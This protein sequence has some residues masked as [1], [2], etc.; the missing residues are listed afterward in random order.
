MSVTFQPVAYPIFGGTDTKVSSFV[1]PAPKL[2][3]VQNAYSSLTGS[4]QRR[5]GRTAI[6][7]TDTNAVAITSFKALATYKGGLLGFA[8][9]TASQ[10]EKV[11][12]KSSLGWV[13]RGQQ[14]SAKVTSQV[15]LSSA[16]DIWFMDHATTA[17]GITVYAANTTVSAASVIAV[18]IQDSNGVTLVNNYQIC[19]SGW[20]PRVV[21]HG[22]M[23][24]IVYYDITNTRISC[25]IVDTSTAALMNSTLAAASTSVATDMAVLLT[26]A[27]FDIVDNAT[28]GVF[29]AY[30]SNVANTLKWGFINSS[31]ALVSTSTYLAG[32]AA[33]AI[34]VAVATGDAMHGISYLTTLGANNVFTL[35]RSWNGAAWTATASSATLGGGTIGASV[36]ASRFDSATQLRVFWSGDEVVTTSTGFNGKMTQVTY[37]T[38]G[39]ITAGSTLRHTSIAS[40]PFAGPTGEHYII[41]TTSLGAVTDLQR[42]L[43]VYR[44]ADGVAARLVGQL[45]QNF[46]SNVP[47][48][49]HLAQVVAVSATKWS[50][51]GGYNIDATNGAGLGFK[52]Y[53]VEWA[54]GASHK[55]IEV[56]ESL[57]VAGSIPMQ[58]DGVSFTESGFLRYVDTSDVVATPS[59]GAGSM[60]PNL[61]YSYRVIPMWTNARGERDLGTDSGAITV[62]LGAA[63]DTVTLSIP[64]IAHTFKQGTTTSVSRANLEFAIYRTEDTPTSDS[65]FYLVGTVANNPAADEVTYVDGATDASILDEVTLDEESLENI[66]PP[67]GYILAQAGGRQWIAGVPGKP[68]TIV[69][70]KTRLP[71]E[72]ILWT[73]ALTID[74]P[75]AGGAIVAMEALGETLVIFKESRIYRMRADVGPNNTGTLGSFLTPELVS[76]DTGCEGQR[77]VAVCP[78]GLMFDGVKGIMLLDQSFGVK[79]IGAPVENDTSIGTV[80][81]AVCL[82]SQQQV[83]FSGSSRTHVYDY[84]HSQWY[85]FTHGSQGPTVEWNDVHTAIHSANVVAYDD[86]ATFYDTGTTVYAM[87]ITLGW[88]KLPQTLQGDMRIQRIGL[89]GIQLGA[90]LSLTV[91][92]YKNF[93][94]TSA[95]QTV[96]VTSASTGVFIRQPRLSQQVVSALRVSITDAV[97]LTATSTA[98]L[99]LNEVVFHVG[100]RGTGLAR[101]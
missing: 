45:E 81:G 32:G 51:P 13:D 77:S 33:V 18:T 75:E 64:T 2:S 20:A 59:N 31:G 98:G 38:G 47:L 23:V 89:T 25:N 9:P 96:E 69:A 66:A 40:K 37:T 29:I 3:L 15:I 54:H 49:G 4:L 90:N 19:A 92:L 42:A 43:Y 57:Y 86:P 1:L 97:G 22:T 80:N 16:D 83:R 52:R 93:D 58:Y 26:G 56:G 61:S 87:T 34:S 82:P 27:I 74:C 71:N 101:T 72:P 91:S 76:A 11:Y 62:A 28:Y 39:T 55:T 6:T 60:A 73:D 84:F 100:V 88:M 67:P 7:S 5:P 63:D 94:E 44:C 36:V 79:Y 30:Y 14:T 21:L 35:L 24:Y 10:A 65:P 68:N 17:A 53:T 46:A 70:S 95:F 99:R 12:D 41:V 85:V 78:M 50:Y 48:F 8:G